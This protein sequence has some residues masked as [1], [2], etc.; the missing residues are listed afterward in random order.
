M[1]TLITYS[2]KPKL[3]IGKRSQ[4]HSDV[5]DSLFSPAKRSKVITSNPTTAG[6]ISMAPSSSTRLVNSRQQKRVLEGSDEK[7]SN[8]L[9]IDEKPIA[10]TSKYPP[11]VHNEQNRS[12]K[13]RR[14]PTPPLSNSMQPEEHPTSPTR[15][16]SSGSTII[17]PSS[18]SPALHTFCTPVKPV[19]S[20]PA[21][22]PLTPLSATP[23]KRTSTHPIDH[24]FTPTK[25]G[26]KDSVGALSQL[27]DFSL[28]PKKSG[29]G[30]RDITLPLQSKATKPVVKRMLGRTRTAPSV[31][32]DLSVDTSFDSLTS[33]SS[34][35]SV[36]LPPSPQSNHVIDP[37]ASRTTVSR[38]STIPDEQLPSSV[39]GPSAPPPQQSN[40][41]LRTY[42]GQ[43]RSFLV[44]LPT[45]SNPGGGVDG[46]DL[47]LEIR[48]SYKDLRMRWGVDDLE[49]GPRP[50]LSMRPSPE[51]EN[52][53]K[54]KGKARDR[55]KVVLPPNMM[56][57]LK[58]ITE[59]RSKG[60]SRRFMDEVGYL[61]EGMERN[62]GVR[63]RRGSA[64]ELVTKICDPDFAR[65]AKA[66]DFLNRAWE[67][68]RAT[69]AG[70]GDKVLDAI[71]VLFSALAAQN[72]REVT[73]L[74]QNADFVPIL[75]DLLAGLGGKDSLE[76]LGTGTSDAEL[77]EAGIGKAEKLIL[78]TLRSVIV[79][80]S[81]LVSEEECPSLRQ[82]LSRVLAS[83]PPSF[84]RP[85]YL[86]H[87]YQTLI[88]GLS[89]FLLVS[90]DMLL[91]SRLS[92]HVGGCTL[93][94]RRWGGDEEHPLLYH[95]VINGN[96]QEDL[97]ERLTTLCAV[98]NIILRN[99]DYENYIPI[100]N[101]CIESA[102]RVLINVSH[103][104][105]TWCRLLLRQRLMIPAISSLIMSSQYGLPNVI[106]E[107]GERNGQAFDRLCLALGTL[108]NLVQVDEDSKDL[109]RQTK[110]DPTCPAPRQCAY[111]CSCPNTVSVM[112]CLTSVYERYLQL[113]DE[114]PGTHIIRGHL[115]VLFGLLMRSSSEN[116]RIILGALPGEG[117]EG[118]IRHAKDFVGLYA[119]FMARVARG[120]GHGAKDAEDDSEVIVAEVQARD[121]ATQDVAQDILRFLESLMDQ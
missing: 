38:T 27:F 2:R 69:G 10:S 68:L 24:T 45:S 81:G 82:L 109:C 121:G 101:R 58:S 117:L 60:E 6:T 63:V 57:D 48:E 32:D 7:T 104:N 26:S 91:D 16:S 76:L 90:Q 42:A 114:D 88:A 43:S 12:K 22:S 97:A 96:G 51:P 72:S 73:D 115:A 9:T 84:H 36:G 41:N 56:N 79:S 55:A 13:A 67:A 25:P 99:P 83:L 100:A 50:A 64:L 94:E 40:P 30:S 52:G 34:S 14:T 102:L 110:L 111:A 8:V 17:T 108:T 87:L 31:V 92:R 120:E 89:L 15:P 70:D 11:D 66:T 4:R 98:C 33:K 95:D 78:V 37:P 74:A 5:S 18:N 75:W 47:G 112:N 35:F 107:T 71:L 62:V 28:K 29:R 85:T 103:D 19:T 23:L 116:Q 93:I 54:G 119:E 61:F 113:E 105:P 3:A 21:P 44:E 106:E 65:R 20:L 77:K 118:L 80:K 1:K 46:D 59:L 86:T 49:D 53:R 39:P